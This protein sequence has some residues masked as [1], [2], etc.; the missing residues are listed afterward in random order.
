MRDPFRPNT[1]KQLV[2]EAQFGFTVIGLLIALLIYV[3]YY[4]INGIGDTLPQHI[5][6][7][8][9]AMHVFPNSPNYDST[10]NS[11]QPREPDPR[12]ASNSNF[13]IKEKSPLIQTPKRLMEDSN[14]TFRSLR[15]T[16]KSIESSAA[17]VQSLA[18]IPVN[19]KSFG[20]ISKPA[21]DA[22]KDSGF[23]IAKKPQPDI[24]TS[25]STIVPAVK[26]PTQPSNRIQFNHF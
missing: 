10:S 23:K 25:E 22:V 18:S 21:S 1:N 3:A 24:A 14:N 16:A 15:K 2:R 13:P 8:P 20:L 11:M 12:V 6:D 5:R 26:Q 4:R 17:K 19:K 9:V 7:A